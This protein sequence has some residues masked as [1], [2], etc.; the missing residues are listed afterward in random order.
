M[1]HPQNAFPDA[2]FL[3]DGA[4]QSL[5]PKGGSV[6]AIHNI[7]A[8]DQVLEVK[9]NVFEYIASGSSLANHID[10]TT[11]ALG[12]ADKGLCNGSTQ[13]TV[14]GYYEL[15]NANVK[16]I[17]IKPGQTIY[18]KFSSVNTDSGSTGPLLAYCTTRRQVGLE[19]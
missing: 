16:Q 6:Y 13:T 14:N 12:V 15:N 3:I 11:G 2:V 5:R 1:A 7:S 19:L 8:S 4:D 10:P 17:T 18:G 9:S